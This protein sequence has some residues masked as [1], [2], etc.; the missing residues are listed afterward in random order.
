[1]IRGEI[2]GDMVRSMSF[3]LKLIELKED[4]MV[5]ASGD[6]RDYDRSLIFVKN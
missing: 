1:M 2:T 3:S 6:K 4:R 5:F